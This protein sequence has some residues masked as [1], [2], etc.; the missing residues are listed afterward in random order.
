[1]LEVERGRKG[2][3]TKD[4]HR[5]AEPEP[6]EFNHGSRSRGTDRHGWGK[7]QQVKWVK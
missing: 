7:D 3:L 1:M 5:A 6:K 4:E 2:D